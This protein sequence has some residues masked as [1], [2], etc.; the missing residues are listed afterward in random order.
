[1][2]DLALCVVLFFCWFSFSVEPWLT[3]EVCQV[4]LKTIQN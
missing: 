2:I 4:L 3:L 1:M